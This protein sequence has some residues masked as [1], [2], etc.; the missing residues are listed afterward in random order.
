MKHGSGLQS[1]LITN[2]C[3]QSQCELNQKE[4]ICS[5][6]PLVLKILKNT[7]ILG[8]QTVKTYALRIELE[9]TFLGTVTYDLLCSHYQINQGNLHAALNAGTMVAKGTTENAI[10]LAQP[11]LW[12][13]LCPWLS[14]SHLSEFFCFQNQYFNSLVAWC[15]FK[16]SKY[17]QHY[18]TL[19]I[20]MG[21][22]VSIEEKNTQMLYL[23]QKERIVSNF[24]AS[25]N[26][27]RL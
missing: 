25:S 16:T 9:E 22:H 10:K 2:A 13:R 24:N 3:A 12:S 6:K 5:L 21:K 26:I 17:Q 27:F 14:L 8:L 15:T 7:N 1:L 19:H 23:Q 11:F 4:I 18:I 20:N